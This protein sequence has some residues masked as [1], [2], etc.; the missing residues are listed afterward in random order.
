MIEVWAGDASAQPGQR[1]ARAGFYAAEVSATLAA[2]AGA[3]VPHPG[4]KAEVAVREVA[5][6]ANDTV[7]L[8]TLF[9]RYGRG[10]SAISPAPPPCRACGA[11]DARAP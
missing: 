3:P 5:A 8:D 10:G 7:Y 6:G 11:G 1:L 4:V 9:E 2:G